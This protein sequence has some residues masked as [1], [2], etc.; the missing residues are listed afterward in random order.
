MLSFIKGN[1]LCKQIPWDDDQE[2]YLAFKEG[3]TGYPFIDAIMT[4]LRTEG[5]SLNSFD[6][7]FFITIASVIILH[8]DCQIISYINIRNITSVG[9]IHHLARHSVACFFTRGDLW[10]S[11]EK[12]AEIFDFYLLDSDWAVNHANWQ[13]LSCSRF[14]HQVYSIEHTWVTCAACFY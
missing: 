8:V 1:A 4:Q 7:L 2:K 12:G 14:F 6:F 9:W 13:W 11:W 3:R 10:Q 5:R